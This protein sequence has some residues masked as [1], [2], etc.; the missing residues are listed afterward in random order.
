MLAGVESGGPVIIFNFLN[1]PLFT[2]MAGKGS[3][4]G[5]GAVTLTGQPHSATLP[6]KLLGYWHGSYLTVSV[7]VPLT[8][9]MYP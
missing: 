2:S 9:A 5:S 4:G 1:L 8:K 7:L 3:L 6:E